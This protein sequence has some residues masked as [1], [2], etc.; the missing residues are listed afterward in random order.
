MAT[1]IIE[2][3][4]TGPAERL[5]VM[6]QDLGHRLVFI[7][8]HEGD[9]IPTDSSDID[10][11]VIMG[12]PGSATSDEPWI[13]D[14]KALVRTLDAAAMPVLGIC[15]GAQIVAH[16]RGG[17]VGSEAGAV[18]RPQAPEA[19]VTS[20]KTHCRTRRRRCRPRHPSLSRVGRVPVGP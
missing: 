3:S 15:L 14:T 10:A 8:P 6:L 7:R 4:S 2:P 11:L 19:L 9:A 1:Y 16:A 12:G 20:T 18:T 5:A 17:E 13:E